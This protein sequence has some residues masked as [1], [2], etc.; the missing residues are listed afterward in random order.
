MRKVVIGIVVLVVAVGGYLLFVRGRSSLPTPGAGTEQPLPAVKAGAQAVAEARVVPVRG[1]T[2]SLPA[3]GTVAQVLVREGEAVKAGQVLVRLDAARQ[4][5]A[6]VAQAE[7]TVRRAQARLADL[8]AGP[9]P[10]E[11]E[12]A[13]SALA[14]AQARYEQVRS[15]ARDQER[16]QAQS[17]VEQTEGQASAARQRVVQ[18]EAALRLAEDELR[19]TE[20]LFGMHAVARQVVEQARTRQQAA[21][22]DLEAA[23]SLHAAAQAQVTAAKAQQS[24]VLAGA[25]PEEIAVAEAEVRRARAQVELLTAAARPE[26]IAAAEADLAGA[27]AALRQAAAALAQ[28]ELRAPFD[29]V[30]VWVGP[31]AGEFAPPGAPVVRLGDLSAWQIETTDLTELGI[32]G[33]RPGSRAKVTF[34][35]IPGLELS[36]KVTE[37]RPYGE[38]RL[39][40]IVYTVVIA[41]DRQDERLRWN[42]TASVAIEPR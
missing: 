11:V 24:L 6:A 21:Q 10:Q 16:A 39:G 28:T 31:K 40:D 25:R 30:V 19:R 17:Q 7:A 42:M 12:A 34:D 23:R 13:R 26:H 18:A 20:Q 32:V 15:G 38:N 33:V 5:A 36:G 8:R 4:A 2:L 9:R 22:A 41:L 29:G 37:I 27:A 14:A 35:A 1:V 3:G